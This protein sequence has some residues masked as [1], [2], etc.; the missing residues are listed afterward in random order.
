[1]ASHDGSQPHY[2]YPDLTLSEAERL[3]AD[4]IK[5][6]LEQVKMRPEHKKKMEGSL[7]DRL[8]IRIDTYPVHRLQ[9]IAAAGVGKSRAVAEGLANFQ[10]VVW[11]LVPNK[12]LMQEVFDTLKAFTNAEIVMVEGRSR[13]NCKRYPQTVIAGAKGASVQKTICKNDE[14]ECPHFQSCPYQEM[15]EKI[16][17]LGDAGSDDAPDG[18]A[19][20]PAL[21]VFVMAHNYMTVP[22]MKGQP[23][24]IIVDEKHWQTFL[25]IFEI[26][27]A[28]LLSAG[29]KTVEGFQAYQEIML[30][31]VE[32][33][34]KNPLGFLWDFKKQGNLELFPALRHINAA[35]KKRKKLRVSPEMETGEIE[36]ALNAWTL[37]HLLNIR[38]FLLRLQSELKHPKRASALTITYSAEKDT[39]KIHAMHRTT[40]SRYTP[41]L[42][43]DA[44]ADL[45]I[46]RLIWS[47]KLL[48]VEMRV[49]RNAFIVQVIKKTFSYQSLGVPLYQSREQETLRREVIDFINWVAEEAGKPVFLAASKRV[50]AALK[51]FLN[52][53]VMSAHFGALR[54]LNAFKDCD[55]CIIL[56]R[57]QPPAEVIEDDTRAL[58]S[59]SKAAFSGGLGYSHLSRNIRRKDGKTEK[60][61]VYL[62]PIDIAQRVLEQGRERESE[63]AID[64]LRAVRAENPKTV[65]I[66][67]DVPLDV[68]VDMTIRWADLKRGGTRLDVAFQQTDKKVMPLS[69]SEMHRIFP[70]I[71]ATEDEAKGDIRRNGGVNGVETVIRSYKENDPF[72]VGEYRL[73]KNQKRWSRGLILASEENPRAALEEVAGTL[74]DFRIV[75]TLNPIGEDHGDD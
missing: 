74:F 57:E 28:D 22:I 53:H 70:D 7:K 58:L 54:G 32:G 21:T 72:Y 55:V 63:Q 73:A 41:V 3:L 17:G 44:S 13:Q 50:I 62:H 48:G 15:L 31:I 29:D 68:T 69:A 61:L 33:I 49:E 60:V 71:W 2:P 5:D 66:L 51:P 43:I 47:G 45:Q 27:A 35:I 1:M 37:P 39:V 40:V 18:A 16:R 36:A 46:N 30:R 9:V 23:D 38:H 6:F 52:A 56:G 25:N 12:V 59:R 64:R 14:H 4:V 67:C 26:P 34:R 75:E 20:K 24:A 8:S 11:Y 42:I 10:G 65:F 19:E